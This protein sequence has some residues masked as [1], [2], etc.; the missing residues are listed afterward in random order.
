MKN[1]WVHL[2]SYQIMGVGN[3]P[4]RMNLLVGLQSLE[5]FNHLLL[6]ENHHDSTWKIVDLFI[7]YDLVHSTP[8]KFHSNFCKASQRSNDTL[9]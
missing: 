7:F 3:L 5:M 9:N 2:R 8:K 1:F 6:R 4:T